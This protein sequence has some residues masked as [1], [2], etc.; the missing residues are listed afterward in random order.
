MA[1][2]TPA[3]IQALASEA[4]G[5]PQLMQSLCL[6]ACFENN[7]REIQA[8]PKLIASDLDAI[9]TICSRTAASCDYSSTVEKMK[10]GPKTRGQDRKSHVLKDG[11]A[12]DV[13]PLVV[14][15]IALDP[16]ELTQ[17]YPNL[18]KRIQAL[19]A[20]EPPSGSSVDRKSVV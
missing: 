12:T 17:R 18:Q 16:P 13:Y 20:S 14:H 10:E 19:C 8:V 3:Y 6:T 1:T 4:A 2:A 5:S 9:K 15:A 11:S 7:I